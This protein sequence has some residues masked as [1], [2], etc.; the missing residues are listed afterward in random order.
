[1]DEFNHHNLIAA[2]N[3][4]REAL[5]KVPYCVPA[6]ENICRIKEITQGNKEHVPQEKSE[7][8]ICNDMVSL[9]RS[10]HYDYF[11]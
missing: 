10:L 1:M 8:E 2:E 5:R 6:M 3:T 11:R 4:F 9:M 7:V